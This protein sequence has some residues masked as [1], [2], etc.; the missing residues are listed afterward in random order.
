MTRF[1]GFFGIAVG[2]I[3]EEEEKKKAKMQ[4]STEREEE[5]DRL[6]KD[7]EVMHQVNIALTFMVAANGLRKYGGDRI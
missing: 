1:G 5:I 7:N 6:T 4:T 2:S 3:E